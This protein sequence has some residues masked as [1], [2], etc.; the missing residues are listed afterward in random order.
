MIHAPVAAT[1]SMSESSGASGGCS[2]AVDQLQP[3][4]AQAA[5]LLES[6]DSSPVWALNAAL[7]A[8][9]MAMF[10]DRTEQFQIAVSAKL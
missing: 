10:R 5:A 7:L 1:D 3:V 6:K 9:S 4:Y 2:S 8:D